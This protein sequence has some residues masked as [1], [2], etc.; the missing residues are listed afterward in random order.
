MRLG[1]QALMGRKTTHIDKTIQQ[2]KLGVMA[3]MWE[4]ETQMILKNVPFP[5]KPTAHNMK[6]W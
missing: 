1:T 5:Y 3:C 4:Q 2:G 6:T